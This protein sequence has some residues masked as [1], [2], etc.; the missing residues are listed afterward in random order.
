MLKI[1]IFGL[2][3]IG[4]RHALLLSKNYKQ[5]QIYAFRSKTHIGLNQLGLREITS[6]KEVSRIQPDIAI[7]A[8]PTALHI[9]TA[10]RCARL[11]C[12]LFIEKPIGKDLGKLN[13]LTAIVKEKKLTTYV[14]YNLRF[15]PVIK[16][17]RKYVNLSKPLH[18]R[19]VCSS[20]LPNWR[21]G[22]N[23]LMSYSAN[24]K[25][26][27]GVLLDLSHEL[28]Y[29]NYFVGEIVTF[30]GKYFRRSSLTVDAEDCADILVETRL[31]PANIHL[32]F[33]SHFSERKIIIDFVGKSIIGDLVNNEILEYKKE[34]LVKRKK[35]NGDVSVTYVDQMKY[36]FKNINNPSMMNSLPEAMSLYRKIVLFKK[37]NG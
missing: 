5:H 33:L 23:Y 31:C 7:I 25:L 2:G 11:N 21:P 22:T 36:F 34:V 12:R 16:A 10:V 35:F 4:R 19:V 8:N 29:V 27:G 6:W 15:H 9:K 30:R 32:N 26:G 20:Y 18:I 1:I 17:L 28:D 37:V 14:A 24:K 3:S 13:Q